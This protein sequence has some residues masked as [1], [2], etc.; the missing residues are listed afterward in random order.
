MQARYLHTGQAIDYI[1]TANVEAGTVVIAGDLV[2]ITKLDIPAGGL[3]CLHVTGVFAVAKGATAISM[4]AKVY[5][6][7]T[8]NQA[9]T[10]V[11]G[12]TL[13]GLAVADAA[14]DDSIVLVRI[15]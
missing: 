15:G 14:Q 12:T 9:V 3:G 1:P 2:G 7:S 11:T 13:I 5:W 10:T 4:G 6:D 8:A